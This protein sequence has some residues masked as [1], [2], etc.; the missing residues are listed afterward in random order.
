MN[1]SFILIG[2]LIVAAIVIGG[3]LLLIWSVNT[4]FPV[5]DI[6]YTLETWF[7]MFCVG[8]IFSSG[9]SYGKRD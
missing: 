1:G 2:G 3:P 7:A 6:P 5:V 8:G 9:R 4:L